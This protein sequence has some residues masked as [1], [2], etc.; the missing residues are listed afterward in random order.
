MRDRGFY[1]SEKTFEGEWNL[2]ADGPGFRIQPCCLL[3]QWTW[4][5]YLFNL[6]SRVFLY[7]LGMAAWFLEGYAMR[8]MKSCEAVSPWKDA[9]KLRG[10]HFP[11]SASKMQNTCHKG[12][13]SRCIF[14]KLNLLSD[15]FTRFW[16]SHAKGLMDFYSGPC[17]SNS[18]LSLCWLW[19]MY[20]YGFL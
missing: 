1:Y 2:K 11:Q 13:P 6:E 20:I 12:T 18:M 9:S 19:M 5:S 14:F 4:I 15:F 7:K 3:P 10:P 16:T 17:S 8:N